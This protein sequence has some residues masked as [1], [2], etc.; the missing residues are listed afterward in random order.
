MSG[1]GDTPAIT[2]L[3]PETRVDMT[4]GRARGWAVAGAI[5]LAFL[6]ALSWPDLLGV[7]LFSTSAV[8][9]GI[10]AVWIHF[11]VPD[12][13]AEQKADTADSEPRDPTTGERD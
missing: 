4:R 7:I 9:L 13:E 3:R 11:A 12:F 6:A 8:V 1:S 5:G 10:V 2:T